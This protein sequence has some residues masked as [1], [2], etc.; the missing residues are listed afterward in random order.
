VRLFVA[1]YPSAAALDDLAV[2]IGGLHIGRA[3]TDGINARLAARRLWHTTIAFLGEMDEKRRDAAIAA[4]DIAVGEGEAAPTL[5]LAGG[6]TFGRGNFVTL[7]VGLAGDV[8][9]LQSLA[10]TVRAK[11]RRA[12]VPFDRKP[13]RP[14]LTI[15]R[16]GRRLPAEQIDADVATLTTYAGPTWP[17]TELVLVQSH[18]GPHPTHVPLHRARL[19]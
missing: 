14:H 4:L 2:R 12:H 3:A 10:G 11:L 18:S 13:F 15:A 19:H 8:V 16:P 17:V 1:A 7:W 9:G 5:R 6:G